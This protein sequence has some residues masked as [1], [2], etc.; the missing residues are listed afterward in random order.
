MNARRHLMAVASHLILRDRAGRILHQRRAGTG[1]A[2]GS[3]SIPAGHV[4]TGETAAET[5]VREAREE[6]GISLTTDALRFVLVQHKHDLDGEERIDLF[7]EADLPVGQRPIIAEPDKCDGLAWA[8]IEAPPS[9]M[10]P[11]V[12]AAYGA[13]TTNVAPA[14]S[15]FGFSGPSTSIGV[16]GRVA[17]HPMNDRRASEA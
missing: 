11:Y 5:C 8:P 2:D 17:E 16:E 14:I 3:W 10:V 4:E 6:I 13:I 1:F 12:A 9:P 15:Y 7:F